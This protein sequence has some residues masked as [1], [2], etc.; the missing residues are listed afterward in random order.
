MR[1]VLGKR[2]DDGRRAE[3]SERADILF[4][5]SD[6]GQATENRD[7][8]PLFGDLETFSDRLTRECLVPLDGGFDVACKIGTLVLSTFT[9][10]P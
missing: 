4:W 10:Q 3:V 7:F 5:P 6:D 9:A 8:N 2:V 1:G